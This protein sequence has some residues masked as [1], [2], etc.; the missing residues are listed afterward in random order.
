MPTG[1]M[2]TLA[3][4]LCKGLAGIPGDGMF[5][6]ELS[7]NGQPPVTHTISSGPLEESFADLLPLTSV[8]SEGLLTTA[9][10]N[11]AGVI[12][13]AEQKGIALTLEQITEL[14]VAID[15]SEQPPFTAMARL[16]IELVKKPL[17]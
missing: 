8:D 1:A 7:S 5:N 10:G 4:D 14:F 15:V 12:Y 9:P 6:T 3:Q 2:T 16:S 11:P 13:L 17:P